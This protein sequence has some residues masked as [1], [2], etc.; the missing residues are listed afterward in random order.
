MSFNDIGV[1]ESFLG[2]RH[3]AE[4]GAQR[5][6]VTGDGERWPQMSFYAAMVAGLSEPTSAGL[7]GFT[8]SAS[9]ARNAGRNRHTVGLN[10]AYKSVSSRVPD[11]EQEAIDS[12]SE[13]PLGTGLRVGPGRWCGTSDTPLRP[14]AACSE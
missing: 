7:R 13:D 8:V 11:P 3:Q 1:P 12:V 4:L 2:I 6:I 14:A 9:G 10:E 5:D